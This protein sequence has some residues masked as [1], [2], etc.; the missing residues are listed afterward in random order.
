MEELAAKLIAYSSQAQ[1]TGFTDKVKNLIIVAREQKTDLVEKQVNSLKYCFEQM[2]RVTHATA[3]D[4]R[5]E[6]EDNR[7]RRHSGAIN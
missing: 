5:I 7:V 4:E 6:V 1:L 2:A 3:F